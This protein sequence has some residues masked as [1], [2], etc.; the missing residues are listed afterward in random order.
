MKLQ[1]FGHLMWITDSFEKTLMLGNIEGWKRRGWQRMRR[2]NGI[3]DSMDMSLSKLWEL[4][5]DRETCHAAFHGVAKSQMQLNNWT[6][7]ISFWID[8][9][10]LLPA[11]GTLKSLL[12]YHS[13]KASILQCSAFFMVQLSHLYM[14]M[15]KTIA[16][17]TNHGSPIIKPGPKLTFFEGLGTQRF[18]ISYIYLS[19]ILGFFT[20]R[21][22]SIHIH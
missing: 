11:Q 22:C 8:W 7:L 14:T 4:V 2:L 12:Q 1:Y 13:L 15:G 18:L 16:L 17:T 3:T 20:Y 19:S 9:F 6:E 10:D 21:W 5:I